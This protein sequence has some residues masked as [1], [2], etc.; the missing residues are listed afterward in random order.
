[1]SAIIADYQLQTKT[2]KFLESAQSLFIDNQWTDTH[3]EQIEVINPANGN[4]LTSIVNATKSDIDTAVSSSRKA[5]E[6]TWKA[7]PPAE[8]SMLIWRLA[9]LIERDKLWCRCQ[10]DCAG[11]TAAVEYDADVS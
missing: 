9:D 2:S 7:T 3:G 11:Q 5:F 4:V 6:T 1:M 8:K 10:R